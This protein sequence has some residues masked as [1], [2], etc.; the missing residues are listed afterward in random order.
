[1]TITG[2]S[3]VYNNTADT[4]GGG[5]HVR[6]NATVVIAGGSSVHS[7][8]AQYGGGGLSVLGTAVVNLTSGAHVDGNKVLN[9]TGGGMVF[10]RGA[11]VF[12]SGHSVISNNTCSGDVGGGI[13]VDTGR[14]DIEFDARGRIVAIEEE[15]DSD[16]PSSVTIS[17]S[18]VSHNKSYALL[19]VGWLWVV[20]VLYSLCMVLS[21]CTTQLSTARVVVWCC[22]A[23]GHSAPMTVSYLQTML[24]AEATLA[25]A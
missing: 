2:G 4:H 22:L 5:M 25:A 19:V 9:G 16:L 24:S 17:N 14:G 12:I 1:V 11:R 10:Y 6:S 3:S 7:N 23:T 20:M 13:A 21:C 18:T 8:S 15:L